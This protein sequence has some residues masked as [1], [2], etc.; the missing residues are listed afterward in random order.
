[1]RTFREYKPI[2]LV[3]II[4]LIVFLQACGNDKTDLIIANVGEKVISQSDFLDRYE[5]F[6]FQTNIKDNIFARKEILNSLISEK[7]LLEYDDNS[8]IM[9]NDEYK[10][11]IIWK[12]NQVVLAYLKDREVYRN[13]NVTDKDTREA[14]LRSSQKIAARHLYASSEEEINE[15]AELLKIGVDFNT[16]ARQTFTDSTLKNN[17]GYLGYFSWGDMDPVF[18]NKAFSMKIGEISAPIRLE[19][20]YSIIKIEDK[21]T[22]P[23]LTESEYLNK[24]NKFTQILKINKKR[25]AEKEFISSI[26][27]LEE[28]K[29]ND[30]QIELIWEKVRLSIES[31]E[32]IGN[33]LDSKIAVE[34]KGANYTSSQLLKKIEMLPHSHF[35]KITSKDKLVTVIKGLIL[36]EELL[37]LADKKGFTDVDLVVNK[38]K[39]LKSKV[40]MKYKISEIIDNS[41]IDDSLI[42]DYYESNK[43]LF[44]S[45]AQINV[46]EI[47][48]DTL[49][50]AKEI[51]TKLNNGHDFNELAQKYS[52]RK[53][54]AENGGVIGLIPAE[55]YG[56]YKNLFARSKLNKIIGPIEIENFYGIF[57]VIDRI[58]DEVEEFEKVKD[59]A[60]IAVKHQYK[61]ELLEKY[62][63]D[64]KKKIKVV[65]NL[66][67][68]GSTKIFQNN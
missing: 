59:L 14:F 20:G 53:Q 4:Y 61:N 57:K 31:N 36:Q 19:N 37:E 62:V 18:E 34:Y 50:L 27:N 52:M 30:V 35:K 2:I 56:N 26:I 58:E 16:L 24:R 68:L 64:L 43:N 44:T 7:L 48:V 60:A 54:T 11:D 49:T 47:I 65:V 51:I 23:L 33:K 21:V 9:E 46:Q 22:H 32:V 55:N 28:I 1:M 66:E 45:H 29:L 10:K 38:M 41:F 12:E 15:L 6:I 5:D 25:P 63:E 13:I 40:F 3:N 39:S 67:N 8:S 17:G 42:L